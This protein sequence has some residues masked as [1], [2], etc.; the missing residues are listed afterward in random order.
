MAN[1]DSSETARQT[2]LANSSALTLRMATSPRSMP[3]GGLVPL[4][5][6]VRVGLAAVVALPI[7]SL[8][9]FRL[10]ED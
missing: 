4:S 2:F 6:R 7:V 5:P 9:G 8:V 1:T 10:I 3:V